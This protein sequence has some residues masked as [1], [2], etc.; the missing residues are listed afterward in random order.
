L[1]ALTLLTF[2]TVARAQQQTPALFPYD[3]LV[4][5]YEQE[6]LPDDLRLKLERLTTTPIVNNAARARG[7]QPMKP[8]ASNPRLLPQE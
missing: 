2:S 4:A 8:I 3:E 7:V 5:L 1:I 6:S